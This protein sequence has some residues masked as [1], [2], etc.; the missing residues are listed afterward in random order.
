MKSNFF[1]M[2]TVEYFY[3]GGVSDLVKRLPEL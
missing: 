1:K 2:D 3:N